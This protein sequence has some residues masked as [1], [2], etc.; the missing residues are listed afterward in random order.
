MNNEELSN[1]FKK[2][3]TEIARIQKVDSFKVYD[4]TDIWRRITEI[5]RDIQIIQTQIREL[6]KRNPPEKK[7]WFFN[8]W[9]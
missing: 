9:K 1:A 3:Q 2:I 5:E 7:G 6:G 4:D 8:L